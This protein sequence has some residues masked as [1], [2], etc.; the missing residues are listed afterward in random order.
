M[1]ARRSVVIAALAGLAVLAVLARTAMRPGSCREGSSGVAEGGAAPARLEVELSGCEEFT[2]SHVCGISAGSELRLWVPGSGDARFTVSVA[3]KDLEAKVTSRADGETL[4]VV[5]P[6]GATRLDVRTARDAAVPAWSGVLAP[7]P[8][9]PPVIAQAI[10]LRS[11]GRHDDAAALLLA[12]LAEEDAGRFAV[13]GL[14]A[15]LEYQRGHIEEAVL[16][17][18]ESIALA[19]A[20]GRMWSAAYDSFA[21]SSLLLERGRFGEVRPILAQAAERARDAPDGQVLVGTYEGLLAWDTGDLRSALRLTREAARHAARLGWA[22]ARRQSEQSVSLLLLSLGRY[23]EGLAGFQRLLASDGAEMLACDRAVLLNHIGWASLL[24]AADADADAGAR[25]SADPRR[26]IEQALTEFRASCP[27][28][29]EIA[30]A[31]ENV[32]LAELQGGRLS[33]AS[34]AL[35][36]AKRTA[37]DPRVP[38]VLFWL[39]LD[40]R[41][42]LASAMPARALAAFRREAETAAAEGTTDDLRMAAEDQAD[43]LLALGRKAGALDVLTRADELV[44]ASGAFIPHGEGK[45]TFF[46]A[47]DRT[48]V[49][50]VSLLVEQGR[51]EEAMLVARHARARVIEQVRSAIALEHLDARAHGRWEALVGEYR[52][53]RREADAEA[54]HDWELSAD[55]LAAALERR[56]TSAT[57]AQALLDEALTVLSLPPAGDEASRPPPPIE[58]GVLELLYFPTD[59]KGWLGFSRDEDGVTARR[60][61]PID[62][63]AGPARLGEAMLAPFDDALARAKRVRLLLYGAL[64]AADVQALLWRGEPLLARK[65]VAYALDV[66]TTAAKA[67]EPEEQRALLVA[68]PNG[69]LPAA[70]EEADAV[71]AVFER[72]PGWTLQVLRNQEAGA[73]PLLAALD[74]ARLFHYAGHAA[75]GGPDG[76]DSFLPLASGGRLTPGDVLALPRVPLLVSLFGCETGREA[77]SGALD[78]TGLATAFLA[79]GARGVVATARVVEDRLARDVATEYYARLLAGGPPDC[80]AALREALLAVQVRS[81]GADWAAFRALTP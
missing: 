39:H 77:A 50:R 24:L 1:R 43:A 64:R 46:G 70:R 54:A 12:A 40:G 69:D 76:F 2:S 5:V 55:R 32:A 22:R 79:A 42:A 37:R 33:A 38:V 19:E 28:P 41:I 29:N 30:N 66:G 27:D 13:V 80:P 53:L 44:A 31:L 7:L 9:P 47:R 6:E 48:A 56:R 58:P 4:R 78:A 67:P 45:E 59:D 81:P 26:P 8:P 18:H 74:D 57:A 3:G 65:V 75:F 21:L 60:L 15:R 71:G 36:E 34:A 16:R 72:T 63:S 23:A 20:E 10:A 49:L 35:A 11:A 17:Y 61:G 68:D 62:P 14:L 52:S 51:A 73:V 25:P